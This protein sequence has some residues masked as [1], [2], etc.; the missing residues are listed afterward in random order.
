MR[1][2]FQK[3]VGLSKSP[4]VIPKQLDR[5]DQRLRSSLADASLE[6]C[7]LTLVSL[8]HVLERLEE[9]IIAKRARG[10]LK[11]IERHHALIDEKPKVVKVSKEIKPALLAFH[12]KRFVQ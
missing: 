2:N 1:I 9:V 5:Y 4:L 6:P 12:Q 11:H 7:L 3:V 10:L 8:L